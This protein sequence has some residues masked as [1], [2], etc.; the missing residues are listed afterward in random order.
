[1]SGP[2]SGPGPIRFAA[3]R[4]TVMGMNTTTP[5]GQ[6]NVSVAIV[7]GASRG[8][9]AALARGLAAQGWRLVIDA[10]TGHELAGTAQELAALTDVVALP[11]DITDDNHRR[12]LAT[13]AED[14]GGARLLVNNASILGGS[15][16]PLLAD[17]P[18]AVL[19]DTF[20][21]NVFAPVALTQRVLPPPRRGPRPGGAE[22]T[23]PPPPPGRRARGGRGAPP[24][25]P[26]HT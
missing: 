5:T 13:A 21:V 8:L 16:P 9:G 2:K 15:P 20:A 11:G 14:L 22:N 7:T 4:G 18:M 23:P 6:L 3:A 19:L 24:T 17:I 25:A 10:R 26:A 12:E 1:M